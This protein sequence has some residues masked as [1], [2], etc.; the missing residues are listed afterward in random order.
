MKFPIPLPP[1]TVL[2]PIVVVVDAH[3]VL[4]GVIAGGDGVVDH[5][6]PVV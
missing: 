2:T 1:D 4:M 6:L 3:T 5:I